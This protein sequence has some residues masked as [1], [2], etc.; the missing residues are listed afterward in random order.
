[1]VRNCTR[2][3]VFQKVR[4]EAVN[5]VLDVTQGRVTNPSMY[6]VLLW[7]AVAAT[8]GC[9][10]PPSLR[11]EHDES[12]E[13]NELNMAAGQLVLYEAQARTANACRP[14]FGVDWQRRACAAKVAP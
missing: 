5:T 11:G 8:A 10:S 3:R 12:L 4:F 6:K 9:S 7:V 14:D 13:Y 1:M 2:D